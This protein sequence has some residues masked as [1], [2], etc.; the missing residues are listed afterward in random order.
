MAKRSVSLS[1]EHVSVSHWSGAAQHASDPGGAAQHT[2]EQG[3][4]AQRTFPARLAKKTEL[5][6]GFY[7]VR[8]WFSEDGN[9]ARW[10]QSLLAKDLVK[11]FE[12]HALDVL[13]LSGIG[14][15]VP[16]GDVDAEIRKL[17]ADSTIVS[18]R[19]GPRVRVYTE[20]QYSTIVASDRVTVLQ[21][22][23]VR[24]YV[25]G[26]TYRCFQHIRLRVGDDSE[27]ISIVN[28]DAPATKQRGWTTD[29]R[30][31]TFRAF[32]KACHLDPFIWGGNLNTGVILLIQNLQSIGVAEPGHFA[33]NS[34][35][36][37]QPE[38]LQLVFSHP[39]YLHGDVALTNGLRTIQTNSEVG[40]SF[41]GASN[42]HDL[43]VAKVFDFA[44][45]RPPGDKC[46][47][48]LQQ[49]LFEIMASKMKGKPTSSFQPGDK[50]L[51]T[52]DALPPLTWSET[53]SSPGRA[54]QPAATSKVT[55]TP[56]TPRAAR[57]PTAA[58]AKPPTILKA[59]A[60]MRSKAATPSALRAATPRVSAIFGSDASTETALQ[61]VLEMISRRSLFGKVANINASPGVVDCY[62]AAIAPNITEKLE[63][64]LRVVEVQRANHLRRM[65][66][67]RADA[68][69]TELHMK[70]IHNEWMSHHNSWMNAATTQ[71]YN[72]LRKGLRKGDHQRARNLQRQAFSAY[73]FQV[74]GS[75]HVLLDCIQRAICSVAQ[76]AEAM[77]QFID[78]WTQE[79]PSKRIATVNE[80]PPPQ[81]SHGRRTRPKWTTR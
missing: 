78:R 51:Q 63:E 45:S 36:A 70:D 39:N 21:S 53:R 9:S 72:D 18:D 74:M 57:R 6:V 1:S 14:D 54:A 17:L 73:L 62:A 20:G 22:K 31:C 2:S 49:E 4:A 43:V 19:E 15:N 71:K 29:G 13:C 50:G 25:P 55:L 46:R 66:G 11:A 16:G 44:G 26:Q 56:G 35:S 5:A 41:A 30:L 33:S 47:T 58:S 81:S 79:K 69:F 52:T 32:R 42:A 65:P 80:D 76:P 28:C 37:A 3:G 38:S 64:F 23:L 48:P 40:V 7:N 67:L 27:P 59:K 60:K 12:D 10:E 24:D 34:T 75:K 77:R 8:I 68:I 61:E